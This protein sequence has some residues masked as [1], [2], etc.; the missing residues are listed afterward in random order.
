MTAAQDGR[1]SRCLPEAVVDPSAFPRAH[2]AGSWAILPLPG[3]KSAQV[4]FLAGPGGC[5][6]DA[7]EACSERPLRPPIC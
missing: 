2:L 5:E 1:L 4:I 7:V 3:E 6:R